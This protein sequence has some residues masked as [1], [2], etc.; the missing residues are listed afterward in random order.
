M[1]NPS[2]EKHPYRGRLELSKSY[3]AKD[4]IGARWPTGATQG[5]EDGAAPKGAKYKNHAK[6]NGGVS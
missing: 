4:T 6:K 3:R 1:L 2:L 5:E